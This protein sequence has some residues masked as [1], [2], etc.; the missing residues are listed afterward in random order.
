MCVDAVP[1]GPGRVRRNRLPLSARC[2]CA[3]APKPAS[4]QALVEALIAALALVPLVLL[5]VWL[6]KVQSLQ[7]AGIA[8]SRSLAF[9]CTVRPEDC[10]DSAAHPELA[11]EV[12]R[13]VFSRIDAPVL[14]QDRVGEMSSADERNPLWVDRAN[15]PL[16]E[17]FADIGV[18]V[19]LETFNAGRALATSRAGSLAEDPL[20]LLSDLAGPG[21]FGLAIDRGIVN[22]RVQVGVSS[23]ATDDRFRSQLDSIPLRMRAHTAV[24]AD[25]W[26]ASG[27]YGADRTSVEQRVDAGSRLGVYEAT[28]DLRYAL[29][30]GFIGLMDVI[31][32][33]PAGGAFRYHAADVDVVPAD[34]VAP[35]EPSHGDRWP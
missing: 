20:A 35:T 23:G 2:A 25:A 10:A 22:A 14:T 31:G 3:R 24:L 19:D 15:R 21:R 27:P 11:D 33:E 13:R 6:G 4:G 26:N 18:R 12:R 17:R 16:I 28:L 9:E 1:R 32:L 30:R 29:T 5:I 34:R 8:A 7:Q